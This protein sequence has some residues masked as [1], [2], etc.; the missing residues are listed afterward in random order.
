M[1]P[2]STSGSVTAASATDPRYL[3]L[4]VHQNHAH[5][6]EGLLERSFT[7]AFSNLVYAQIWEDPV[8]DLEALALNSTSRLVVIASGGCN[9]MSYLAAGP[10]HITAVDLNR[11]HVALNRLKLAAAANVPSHAAFRRFFAGVDEASNINT[12]NRYVRPNLDAETASYWDGRDLAGRR[13]ISR[14]ARN[15]YRYG[16]LGRFITAAHLIARLHGVDP[17]QIASAKTLADQRRLFE[18]KIAPL[19]ERRTIRWLI[20][21]PAVLFG[22]GIPPAQYKVLAADHPGGI[23]A[24]LRERLERLICGFPIDQNYFAMQAFARRYD[25]APGGSVPPYLELRHFDQ[26]SAHAPSV[27]VRCISFTAH[28]RAQPTASLDRYVLLDAQDWMSNDDLTD[29]WREITRTARSGA[30]VIF[31]TAATPT[32]L[33]GRVPIEILNSWTYEA[34][35][36]Q[37]WTARDRSAIYGGFHLYVKGTAAA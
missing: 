4:A 36:S 19:L 21:R 18:T 8:I 5:S 33:P 35:R 34:E 17:A 7:L 2:T 9:M 10:A 23:K 30:R 25:P 26:L 32:L 12:Y 15:I 14:F 29:L 27:D 31:R 37:A 20:D 6:R 16:L 11:A 24:V 13:R 3:Q 22:L 1:T 28:L